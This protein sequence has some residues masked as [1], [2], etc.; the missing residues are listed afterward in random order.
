MDAVIKGLQSPQSMHHFLEK[1]LGN[2]LDLGLHH[3][4]KDHHAHTY[5]KICYESA[6]MGAKRSRKA[7]DKLVQIRTKLGLKLEDCQDLSRQ[8]YFQYVE[9]PPDPFSQQEQRAIF[10]LGI[11]LMFAE[12]DAH[13]NEKVI[14]N[15]MLK[16]FG[17]KN[18][19]DLK[20][21]IKEIYN[22]SPKNHVENISQESHRHVLTFLLELCSADETFAEEEVQFL[23][24][25]I[26]SMTM[27]S[28]TLRAIITRAELDYGKRI[29]LHAA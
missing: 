10:G 4:F 23:Q 11:Q 28:L 1:N 16:A 20:K 27:D 19:E 26:K 24:A 5:Y 12:Q 3:W 6:F 22:V 9:N 15:K 21:D 13:I 17:I 29:D 7:I 8:Y 2:P 18:L 25:V 14:F